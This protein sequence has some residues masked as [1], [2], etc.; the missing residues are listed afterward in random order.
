[1][2][3]EPFLAVDEVVVFIVDSMVPGLLNGESLARR[4]DSSD[5]GR[6]TTAFRSAQLLDSCLVI[7]LLSEVNQLEGICIVIYF[8]LQNTG[9][10]QIVWLR[11]L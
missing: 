4:R 6:E 8:W 2:V 9:E 7:W 3:P 1:M 11:E 5:L 10:S